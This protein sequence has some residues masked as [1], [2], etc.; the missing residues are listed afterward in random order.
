MQ[1][2]KILLLLNFMKT[3][4]AK[5][6][7]FS[8]KYYVVDAKDQVLGRMA[9][10]IA[11]VLRGRQKPIYTPHTDTGDFVIVI[12]ADKVYVSGNKEEKKTYM[13]YSGWK[14]GEKYHTFEEY[15][16]LHP[17]RIIEL[18]VRR[19]LP[20]NKLNNQVFRKLKVYAGASH[21][22]EAQNP[23]PFPGEPEYFSV[24]STK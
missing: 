24:Q 17:E 5:K 4:L 13:T 7:G 20:K 8:R 1:Y 14:G 9:V 22:H 18:A 21:P 11:N 12:N 19:M 23:L 3:T 2:S 16:E 15:R 6:E 10:K